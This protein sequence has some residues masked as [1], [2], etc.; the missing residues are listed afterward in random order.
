MQVNC[1][2]RAFAIGEPLIIRLFQGIKEPESCFINLNV[3]R[4]VVIG[5]IT[6]SDPSH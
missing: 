4:Q 5:V 2:R 1:H 6:S 3:L